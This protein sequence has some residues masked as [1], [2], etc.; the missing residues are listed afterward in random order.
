[1]YQGYDVDTVRF[2]G[3]SSS[4]AD[5]LRPMQDT[6]GLTNTSAFGSVPPSTCNFAMVD[7]S[8]RSVAYEI[9]LPTYRRMGNSMDGQVIDASKRE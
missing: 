2:T 1:M 9:D 6:A 8:V 5:G 7:G 4:S 3:M